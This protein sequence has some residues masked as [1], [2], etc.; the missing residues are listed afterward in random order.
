MH[1]Y[2]ITY[3]AVNMACAKTI[4]ISVPYMVIYRRTHVTW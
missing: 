3:I 2:K 1:I 4:S